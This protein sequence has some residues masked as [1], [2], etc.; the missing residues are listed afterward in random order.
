MLDKYAE[1]AVTIIRGFGKFI[2]EI[3]HY[4]A[5]PVVVLVVIYWLRKPI[6]AAIGRFKKI[7]HKDTV[8][9]FGP[10]ELN[11]E[12]AGKKGFLEITPDNF[13]WDD[14]LDYI[15]WMAVICGQLALATDALG[16][17]VN[18]KNFKK[19]F[20]KMY[21]FLPQYRPEIF[22]KLDL[23]KRKIDAL[24]LDENA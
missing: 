6:V 19:H 5:W 7:Q 4:A 14:F 16:D 11:R 24:E 10:P 17:R 18:A 22:R 21:E 13:T 23:Y 12:I 8:F 3:L 20:D 9:E 1:F 15:D 2:I